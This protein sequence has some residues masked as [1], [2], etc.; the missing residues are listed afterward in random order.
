MDRR[1]FLS[2]GRRGRQR[3]LELSCER[4][5][6]R[7]V[8]AEARAARMCDDQDIPESGEPPTR[9]AAERSED[10]LAELERRLGGADVLRV[11]DA[12]WLQPTE[13]RLLVESR[14][15]A[16]RR[17]GGRIEREASRTVPSPTV[18]AGTSALLV[19]FATFAL[20]VAPASAQAA[21]DD[22][23]R[24]RVEAALAAAS[25][26]PADSIAVQ[27]QGGVVTLSGSV[28]CDACGGNATPGGVG[29]VQQSLGAVVRAIPGVRELRF[30]IRYRPPN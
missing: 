7:W 16:F 1:A 28:L 12:Q 6:M 2:L 15:E 17:R 27:V 18:R 30:A 10:L 24:A 23:L 20:A 5:Y 25:D 9:I 3:V 14:I 22:V 29:T 8:D 21:P 19:A 4:L 26:L 11:I 13:L